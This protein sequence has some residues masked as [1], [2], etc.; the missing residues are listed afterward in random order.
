MKRVLAMVLAACLAFGMSPGVWGAESG[1]PGALSARA[2]VGM[3]SVFNLAQL[4][5]ALETSDIG[6]VKIPLGVSITLTGSEQITIPSDKTLSMEGNL[7]TATTGCT[8]ITNLGNLIVSSGGVLTLSSGGHGDGVGVSNSGTVDIQNG[9]E[10]NITSPDYTGI[11]ISSH[12]T[13]S[14]VILSGTVNIK[15][16]GYRSVGII[17]NELEIIGGNMTISS[18]DGTG[19][20]V[21]YIDMTGGNIFMNQRGTGFYIEKKFN[22]YG[23]SITINRDEGIVNWGEVI[24]AGGQIN[25]N[26]SRGFDNQWYSSITFLAKKSLINGQI[27]YDTSA[28]GSSGEFKIYYGT[29]LN[30]LDM[31]GNSIEYPFIYYNYNGMKFVPILSG[32][33]EIQ[34]YIKGYES[35]PYSFDPV[36][37]AQET[38]TIYMKPYIPPGCDILSVNQPTGA[39][40][41]GTSISAT[42]ANNV[43]TQNI[44][45]A[46]SEGATWALYSDYYC[47]KEIYTKQ[48]D[49]SVGVNTAYI[50]V[51][52]EGWNNHKVYTLTITRA[53]GGSGGSGSSSSSGGGGG[54]SRGGGSGGGG[55]VG[56]SIKYAGK[57]VSASG[58]IIADTVVSEISKA[59]KAA[60]GDAVTVRAKNARIVS[61]DT[62][63]KMREAAAKANK[64]LTFNADTLTADGRSVQGRLSIGT[65]D[66]ESIAKT[67]RLGVYTD[68]GHTASALKKH[69]EKYGKNIVIISCD[70]NGSFGARLKITV[71]ADLSKLNTESL[72]LYSYNRSSGTITQIQNPDYSISKAGYLSFYTRTGGDIIISDRPLEL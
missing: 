1:E 52:S 51:I 60:Q 48:V 39:V 61:P 41:K 65:A 49:L 56:S 70:Q 42:V 7:T 66:M 9:G 13:G 57:N 30:I 64:T 24:M 46:V 4:K 29:V 62:L 23:G 21:E 37:D 45:V 6:T 40:I 3:S 27:Y 33:T 31:E 68:S 16:S 69:S 14:K 12:Y 19:V 25:V 8:T 44:D 47:R 5:L 35:G 18:I 67:L 17:A 59:A 54:S 28:I 71:K 55:A 32:N 2:T 72:Y 50:E 63:K 26:S 36:T 34:I 10:L 22:M 53:S 11:G 15:N 43:T 58:A 38:R 20:Q